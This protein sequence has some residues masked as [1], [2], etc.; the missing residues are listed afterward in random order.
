MFKHLTVMPSHHKSYPYGHLPFKIKP[1]VL[2]LM[3]NLILLPVPVTG[4]LA[5]PLQISQQ[6]PT[7]PMD[8]R[9]T[10][11]DRLFKEG[12]DL[13]QQNTPQSL[14]QALERWEKA[15]QLY[16][17]LGERTKKAETLSGM[18][19]IYNSMGN[20]VQSVETYNQALKLYEELNDKIAIADTL[21]SVG[22]L[23]ADLGKF[24]PALEAYQQAL[25]LYKE[26]KDKGGE[27][28]TLNNMG[29]VYDA[30]SE[31]Q[32]ALDAYN[33]ALPLWREMGEKG[34]QAT[35]LNNIGA[36]YDSLGQYQQA[37][38]SYN[39]A[40]EIYQEVGDKTGIPLTLNNLGLV[41]S[42]TNQYPAA[43]ELYEKA[44]PLWQQTGNKRRKATTLNNIGFVYA[45]TNE[46]EKA[47]D[48]YNLA[49]PLWQ[50]AG[51]KRGEAS[52]LNN[53]GFVYANS[54]DNSKAL[55]YYN[56]ALTL[57]RE[58]GDRPKEALTLYRI[59]IAQREQGNLEEAKKEIELALEI[60][61][62]LRTKVDSQ[63]LRA[64][65]FASKQ[66][67][68]EF[69]IDLLMQMHKLY[70]NKNYQALALQA[71][72]RGRAR[73]LLEILTQAG[74]EIRQGVEPELLE[75]E[76]T[77]Q[78][79]LA[80][81]EERRSQLLG[82]IYKK[83]QIINISTEITNLLNEYRDVQ[84]QIRE[85][86][87][88]YAALTQPQPLTL[89]EIQEKVLDKDT[90]LLEYSLGKE[91]S[92]LW[93]VTQDSITS[94]ELPSREKI[95]SLSRQFRDSV[96]VPTLRIRRQKT[97]QF[98]RA[99]SEMI[100]QPVAEKLDNKRLLVVSDGAL[101]YIPFAALTKAKQNEDYV[102]LIVD[103]E[104]VSLPSASTIGVLRRELAG[105]KAASKTL[106]VLAD[107][108]F[109]KNDERV[110]EVK[111]LE[112]APLS[113]ANDSTFKAL[114][115]NFKRLPF[116]RTEAEEILALVP[117]FE[118][119]KA[120]G[121]A[122]NRDLATSAELSNY[123]I[124]HFA[125]HGILNSSKPELSGLVLSLVNEQG[126]AKDG[127]LA[128]PDIFNLNLPAELIVLSAC[129]TGLGQQIRGEGLVGLT[130]GFMYAG[131]ARVVVSLWSVDDEA[132]AEL[133]TN[134]YQGMLKQGLTP[135]AALRAAQIEMWQQK[136]WQTP[137][138][139]AGFTLQGEWQ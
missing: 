21:N 39:Q 122:A 82:G 69:Y 1:S 115:S 58:V 105:R 89:A 47:L 50:Q 62:D 27:A 92:Y 18:A 75:K 134:F 117:D 23:N 35:T 19:S 44:L 79:Q 108:V 96:M 81:L 112:F 121:F 139:W 78:E 46:L 40:L 132:T 29:V 111:S 20:K 77:L 68:Y 7:V 137:F 124:V 87:P 95:E 135:T 2:L 72:E 67:Y 64:S 120:F 9:R 28:Y 12:L 24:D 22:L 45:N 97:L 113:P 43:L 16:Q 5:K 66:D 63:E 52:T 71:S 59:A 42:N 53:L 30:K 94:Y 17:T 93:L 114:G 118:K 73:S 125:T 86:S 65:F 104:L 57:R 3:L 55:N 70:P 126:I 116:T 98:S 119:T 48:V 36:I 41:Y 88:R 129:E 109:A 138:F 74:A 123:K 90:V 8:T 13:F 61:E 15:L 31:Y 25:S 60:I 83:E 103:N 33:Q 91:R 131:A 100:L 136:D 102:P 32:K 80:A 106:A 85:T 14:P 34:V 51:D 49:L 110:K 56:Q 4:T 101:Q 38:E 128:L 133:M 11:A 107:P 127:F 130:R 76:S 6:T 10:E 99:L 37:L 26:S 54:G 84:A